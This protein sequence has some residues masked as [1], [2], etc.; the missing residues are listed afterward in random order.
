MARISEG[1]IV[2]GRSNRSQ[3]LAQGWKIIGSG[4]NSLIV[5]EVPYAGYVMGDNEQARMPA[6]IGWKKITDIIT[7]RMDQIIRRADA[8]IQKAIKKLGL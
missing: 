2:P 1:S 4:S 6:K 8:G 5:N 3:R 7:D